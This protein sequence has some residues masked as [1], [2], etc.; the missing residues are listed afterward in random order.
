MKKRNKSSIQTGSS[1]WN[2]FFDCSKIVA[3]LTKIIKTTKANIN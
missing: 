2:K 3:T 1:K